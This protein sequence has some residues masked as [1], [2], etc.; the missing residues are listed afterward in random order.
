MRTELYIGVLKL[1][2]LC[3][4]I[5]FWLMFMLR[6][7]WEQVQYPHEKP[8]WHFNDHYDINYSSDLIL[9]L[10]PNSLKSLTEIKKNILQF[11]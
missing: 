10:L 11:Q 1:A 8:S 4:M 7:H 5:F 6:S 3:S 2:I 9:W